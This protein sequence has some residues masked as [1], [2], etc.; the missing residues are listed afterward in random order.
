MRLVARKPCKFGGKQY[1]IGSEVPSEDVSDPKAKEGL[2]VLSI[3]DDDVATSVLLESDIP[4]NTLLVPV[5]KDSDEENAQV[6]SVPISQSDMTEIFYILQMK[7]E[8]AIKAIGELK[9]EDML[10]IVHALDNRSTVKS[11][12][13]KQAQLIGNMKN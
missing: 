1:F 12:A 13:K 8:A 11:A 7:A 9:N 10:I 5:V 3:L 6:M 4:E 2:G